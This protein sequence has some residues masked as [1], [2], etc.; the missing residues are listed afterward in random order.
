MIK[1]L[2]ALVLLCAIGFA[3]YVRFFAE[4]SI[5]WETPKLSTELADQKCIAA[6]GRVYY[7]KVPRGVK[8]T[9]IADELNK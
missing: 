1:T 2:F 4:S 3:A 7:G 9:L 5:R 6:D 8:C